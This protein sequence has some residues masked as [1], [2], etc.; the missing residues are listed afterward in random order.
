M[1]IGIVGKPNVG[2]STFFKALTMIPVEIDNRPFVTIKPNYG[3]G[4]VRVKEPSFELNL[5]VNPRTGYIKGK[6]RFVPIEIMDVAGLVPGAHEGKGLG[7]KFLDD[8]RQAEGFIMV[9]DIVGATNEEGIYIGKG[10]YDPINDIKFLEEELDWWFFRIIKENLDKIIRKA[11]NERKS[12]IKELANVL[13]GINISEEEIREAFK[14]LKI[15]EYTYDFDEK[16]IFELA[17]ILR[18]NKKFVI[19]ANRVDIDIDLAKNNIEKIKRGYPDKI[20]IPTSAQAELILKELDK[21]GKI[22]YIPGE[23]DIIIKGNLNDKEKKAI[24]IIKMIIEEFDSTGVQITLEKLVFD[25]LNYIP[26]FPVATEK[27][28]DTEGNILPD[29]YLVKKGTTALD[30][31]YKIHTELGKNFVKARELRFKKI[32][33]K[34]YILENGDIIQIISSH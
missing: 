10:N 21:Q 2:K 33:G 7:N 12:I 24:E 11:K 32:V 29:C 6:Y 16:T 3:I 20:I 18:K 9:I 1:L 14:E 28:T 5:K 34:D 30:L 19:A 8:L 22:E 15:D 26:V 23:K 13:S 4:Y 31:A 27:Y 17:K 25:L